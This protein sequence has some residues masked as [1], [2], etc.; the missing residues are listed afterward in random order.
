MSRS[1]KKAWKYLALTACLVVAVLLFIKFAFRYK[2]FEGSVEAVRF[3]SYAAPDRM[4]LLLPVPTEIPYRVMRLSVRTRKGKLL[5][6]GLYGGDLGEEAVG[7]SIKGSYKP[8][9]MLSIIGKKV[10]LGLFD[11]PG[12]KIGLRGKPD[13]VIR[14]Y[15]LASAQMR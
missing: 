12:P 2:S 3:E 10:I 15:E 14:S 13:G 7:K 11:Y 4:G 5:D 1:T 8:G 6:L 9:K